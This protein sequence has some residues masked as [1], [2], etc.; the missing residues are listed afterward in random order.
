MEVIQKFKKNNL[1]GKISIFLLNNKALL[2]LV[3]ILIVAQFITGG[4]TF[5]AG[6]LSG[7]AR[8]IAVSC[9]LGIGF[10][11]LL[12]AGEVDL[13]VAQ[14]MNFVGIVF[15]ILSLNMPILPAILLA[16]ALG[17]S[18]GFMNGA[19]AHTF[20]LPP[21]ILT[22]ATAQIFKGMGYILCGGKSIS[23]LNDSVKFIGQGMLFDTIPFS[24]VIMMA[25]ILLMATVL[26][27]TKYGRYI[28]ATG[29]N[30]EAARVSGINIKK[31]RISTYV[32]TGMFV[33][34][35]AMILSGRV[36]TALPNSGD[37]MEMD[38]IAAVVI[39][40]TPMI[41]GKAKVF[42][43]LFGCM[44]M[45]F[46]SNTLNLMSVSSFWQYIAKGLIIVLAI[47]IDAQTEAFLN[48]R[49]QGV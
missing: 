16:V 6:N 7:V 44:I 24:T 22:L 10:T 41:G 34:L 18:C 19:I 31:I 43:T 15:G 39:G 5:S 42:G 17:A 26:Y 4:I 37:G 45:G 47:V 14:M 40:G 29:G 2:I 1:S 25:S 35:G 13:S 36:A 23:G 46:I 3:L 38:A 28:I 9:M 27:K 20:K 21:F 12:A 48:R 8:Q 33:A 11:V 32:V 49:K 30:A